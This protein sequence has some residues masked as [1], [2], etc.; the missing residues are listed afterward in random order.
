MIKKIFPAFI[1]LM[2]VILLISSCRVKDNGCAYDL[3]A[4]IKAP[5]SEIVRLQNYITSNNI[6]ATQHSSGLFYQ[7]VNAGTG[8]VPGQCNNVGIVYIGKLTNGQGFDS[9][10]N[11]VFLPL[12]NLI[13]GWRI[14]LPLIKTGGTIKLY[15]PPSFGYGQTDIKNGNTVIIPKNSILVF[16]VTLNEVTP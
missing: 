16:D 2:V 10:S 12:G 11:T 8:K 1:A 15:I 14:G 4:G 9:S 3:D 7:V 13:Y 6:T 5:D